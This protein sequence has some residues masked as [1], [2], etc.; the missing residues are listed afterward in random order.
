MPEGEA[1]MDDLPE[2]VIGRRM[3][4]AG[5]VSGTAGLAASP[6]RADTATPP[7]FYS[8][9]GQFIQLRP[10]LAAPT[11][12]IRTAGGSLIDFAALAGN[13]II[14]NFWATW[15]VPCVREMPALDRLAARVRG[16][17]VV[18]LPI[19]ID[20]AGEADV[21]AFYAKHGLTHLPVYV[22]PD[23]QV[24]HLGHGGQWD[25]L[26]PLAALPTTF[27]IDPHGDVLGY[28]PGAAAWDSAQAQ[29]L[30]AWV[31]AR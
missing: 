27:L 28:V 25:H 23:Q 10:K 11:Q 31:A 7:P 18:V 6:A 29:A 15:C 22:D 5:I 26:F 2:R 16:A 30:I 19:A 3:M 17:A 14:V 1:S 20:A 12:P 13:V 9:V 21:P 8:N 24:G 4:L